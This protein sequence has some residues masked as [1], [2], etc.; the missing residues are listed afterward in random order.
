MPTENGDSAPSPGRKPT[1]LGWILESLETLPQM[2]S[3]CGVDSS[4]GLA[5]GCL[6]SPPPRLA[7]EGS[8]L[9]LSSAGLLTAL[10]YPQNPGCPP[11][12]GWYPLPSPQSE[13]TAVCLVLE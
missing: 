13:R 11:V 10:G 5:A 2:T 4:P 3:A 9:D 6:Q 12:L 8:L 1:F 7:R